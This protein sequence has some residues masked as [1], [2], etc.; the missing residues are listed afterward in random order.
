MPERSADGRFLR[1]VAAL[2]VDVARGPYRHLPG[3]QLWGEAEDATQYRGPYP[4]VAHPPC[5]AWGAYAHKAHDTGATG[6]VGVAQVRAFGGVLEHPAGSKLWAAC[7]MPK[8]GQ[9]VDRWGGYTVEVYQRDWH[10]PADK[11]TWLYIVGCAPQDLPPLPPPQPKAP[12]YR[13]AS[14][15]TSTALERMAKSKRHLTPPMFASWLV[16][17]A[18]RCR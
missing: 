4:V 15:R 14:G 3:V 9:G 5:G 2:Y 10:H 11:K 1:T 6:P 12:F 18:R 13:K 16:E 7:G 8:P 17:I